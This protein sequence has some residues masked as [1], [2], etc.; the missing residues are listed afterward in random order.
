MVGPP[1]LAKSSR[2]AL[3]IFLPTSSLLKPNEP[4]SGPFIF[5]LRKTKTSS[6]PS[7][8]PNT[9]LIPT[10][11]LR[12][13]ICAL[14]IHSLPEINQ[15][16]Q[17]K[18]GKSGIHL[19][20]P[21]SYSRHYTAYITIPF[22]NLRCPNSPPHSPSSS[23][24]PATP[25]QFT[26]ST[27]ILASSRIDFRFFHLSFSTSL[28]NFLYRSHLPSENIVKGLFTCD[29]AFRPATTRFLKPQYKHLPQATVYSPSYPAGKPTI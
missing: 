15:Q 22:P 2:G 8:L 12:L 24:L 11:I 9:K 6:Q 25:P 7:L 23:R 26:T 1:S 13:D 4:C 28:Q 21:S 10:S 18:A 17:P 16:N 19:F 3:D 5:F 29:F 20:S 14:S 27:Q